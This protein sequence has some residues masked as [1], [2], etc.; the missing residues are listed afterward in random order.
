MSRP[1]RDPALVEMLDIAVGAVGFFAMVTL[2]GAIVVEVRGQPALS[3]SLTLLGLVV[4][5]GIL[6]AS[7]RRAAAV[8]L[9]RERRR[10][11]P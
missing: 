10:R 4:L 11:G 1:Q 2:V 8:A 7:R 5:I 9:A 6:W 3:W